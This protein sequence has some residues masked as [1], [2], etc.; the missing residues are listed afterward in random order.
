MAKVSKTSCN[1]S[2]VAVVRA[3]AKSAKRPGS[4]KSEWPKKI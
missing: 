4:A 1:S 2:R 3:T